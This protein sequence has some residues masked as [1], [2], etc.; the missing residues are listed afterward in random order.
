MF[1]EIFEYVDAIIT[2]VSPGS[3]FPPGSYDYPEDPLIA[4]TSKSYADQGRVEETWAM[5]PRVRVLRGVLD[6]QRS[7]ATVHVVRRP[8]RRR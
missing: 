3:A 4:W 5:T 7:D 8:P 1:L 2:P 6:D